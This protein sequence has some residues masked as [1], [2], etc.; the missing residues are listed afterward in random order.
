MDSLP[1]NQYRQVEVGQIV[2][3]DAL[4]RMRDGTWVPATYYIGK[5][6]RDHY[7]IVVVPITP[8]DHYSDD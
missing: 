3:N 7:I 4:V 8:D 6:L 1:H 5:M 2:G